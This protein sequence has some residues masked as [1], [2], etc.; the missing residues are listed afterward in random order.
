MSKRLR[1]SLFAVIAIGASTMVYA[2]PARADDAC[3]DCWA[4][5]Y[6]L[7]AVC[8]HGIPGGVCEQELVSCLVGCACLPDL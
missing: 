1:R 8:T 6:V 7:Y 3:E 4:Y 2:R 5:C